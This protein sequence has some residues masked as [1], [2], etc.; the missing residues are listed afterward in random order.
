[1]ATDQPASARRS[2]VAP[3]RRSAAS[4]TTRRD[5]TL[6]SAAGPILAGLCPAPHQGLALD[7]TIRVERA[8]RRFDVVSLLDAHRTPRAAANDRTLRARGITVRKTVDLI[9]ATFC[10]DESDTQLHD[11]RDFDPMEA[12]LGLRTLTMA[13]GSV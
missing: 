11:D 3:A 6:D 2:A 4:D 8:L 9:I 13:P 12:H 5:T 10:I 7:G 1:M